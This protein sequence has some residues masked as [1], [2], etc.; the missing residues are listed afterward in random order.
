MQL[1]QQQAHFWE[2]YQQQDNYYLGF[3]I[4]T[5]DAMHC[6]HLQLTDQQI[7]AYQEQG[8]A[9]L[10]QLAK[11]LSQQVYQ[12]NFSQLKAQQVDAVTEAKMQAAFQQWHQT[13]SNS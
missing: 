2:L 5:G 6:W 1:I 9:A 10:E 7:L 13:A 4:D 11:Q 3:A 12:A 8:R